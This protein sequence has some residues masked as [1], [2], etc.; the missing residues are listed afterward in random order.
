VGSAEIVSARGTTAIRLTRT[1]PDTPREV[2]ELL[3]SREQLARWFPCDVVVEGG[4]WRVGA[5][6][7]F[8]FPAANVDMTLAGVVVDVDEPHAL[9][10]TWGDE[11]LRFNVD[12]DGTNSTLEVIDEL[13]P[14]HA[15]RNAAGWEV[16]LDRLMGA[17]VED[18]AWRGYFERYC[19]AFEPLVGPQEG[20]P[21]GVTEP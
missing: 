15:A 21:A 9:A 8:E 4:Q 1:L 19:E 11:T 12:V 17:E 14:A 6:I 5:T 16:C 3:T 10:F 2:W 18:N 20:P 7:R 13:N